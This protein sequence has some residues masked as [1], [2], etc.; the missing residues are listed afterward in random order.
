VKSCFVGSDEW[1]MVGAD[2][3]ALESR[4]NALLTKDPNKLKVYT[5]G[6]DSH[7]INASAY[8]AKDMP[9]IDSTSVASVNSIIE[10]YPKLRQ[11][12]KKITF[13]AQYGGTYHTFMAAGFSQ[14]AAKEIET[15][16]HKFYKV[17]D[18]WVNEK[19]KEASEV[20]YATSA[21]GLRVRTPL[22]SQVILNS[23]TVPYAA[24]AEARTL[25][26]AISGQSFGLLNNRATN[27][28]MKKVWKSSFRYQIL[29][30]SEI[31][32][33]TYFFIR[34]KPEVI[35]FTNDNLIKEMEWQE[36]PEI[37]HPTVKLG[38]ALDVFKDGWH[39]PITLVNNASIEEIQKALNI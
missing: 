26:N 10:K 25:G 38:A 3:N 8:F 15:N 28:F 12:S 16:Y 6:F 2:F 31:H 39:K 14:T 18:D 11:D 1:V 21:F 27:A 33:A 19:T 20:G 29:P 30:I 5:E 32:D 34:N 7:C 23:N 36:L 37:K 17:S 9:D 35:K 24:S 13:A 22:L 4:I